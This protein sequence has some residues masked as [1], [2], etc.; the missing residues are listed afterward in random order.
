MINHT[1]IN[2]DSNIYNSL[3][4]ILASEPFIAI[5]T[6]FSRFNTY[7]PTQSLVQI[8]SDKEIFIIDLLSITSI[9]PIKEIIENEKLLKVIHSGSQD[10]ELFNSIKIKPQYFF[11][12]QIAMSFLNLEFGYGFDKLIN[13]LFQENISKDVQN[14]NWLNRPLKEEQLQYAVMDV[15]YLYKAFIKLK[16]LL[17]DRYKYC[18]SESNETLLN[19]QYDQY[20][21]II[22]KRLLGKVH[23]TKQRILLYCLIK[24]R[25]EKAKNL[26]KARTRVMNDQQMINAAIY[27]KGI[28][29]TFSLQEKEAVKTKV[30]EIE[31]TYRTLRSIDDNAIDKL[32]IIVKEK[33]RGLDIPWRI[34][35]SRKELKKFY[36]HL[37]NCIEE[38]WRREILGKYLNIIVSS[39]CPTK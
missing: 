18:L 38:G 6:E 39:L 19:T 10:I 1:Y 22:A 32:E 25:E 27:N 36:A 12:T 9:A 20:H 13:F 35:A 5:D 23:T 21:E 8:A 4:Q 28:P 37:P 31:A 17:G 11:D 7:Y 34:L 15:F 2:N 3:P 16:E 30:K 14:S 24:W 33:A 26:N 29:K